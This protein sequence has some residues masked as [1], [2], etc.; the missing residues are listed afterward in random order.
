MH[1]SMLW[2]ADGAPCPAIGDWV[3]VQQPLTRV[4]PDVVDLG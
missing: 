2:V 1:T 3:D 4:A